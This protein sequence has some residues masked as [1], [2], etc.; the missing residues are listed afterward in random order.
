MGIVYIGLNLI[1]YWSTFPINETLIET[2]NLVYC[3]IVY[4]YH[5]VFL[6][7]MFG[8]QDKSAELVYLRFRS[9]ALTY[10]LLQ[11]CQIHVTRVYLDILILAKNS[12]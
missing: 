3:D 7:P 8:T 11:I 4:G 6:C 1:G 9:I 12:K 2:A 5:V 10:V